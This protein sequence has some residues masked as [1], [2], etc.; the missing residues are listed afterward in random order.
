MSEKTSLAWWARPI[1]IGSLVSACLLPFGALGSR[2]GVWTFSIGFLLGSIGTVVA[3]IGLVLAL[4]ALFVA[5]RSGRAAERLPVGMGLVICLLTLAVVGVQFNIA[6]SVPPIHNISTDVD[7]PPE[8]SR[9]VAVRGGDSNL[10]DYDR[11]RLAPLQRR[12]YPWVKPLET[13]R[14]P[15]AAFQHASDLVARLGWELVHADAEAGLIEATDTSLWFGFKDD[16]VIRIRPTDS[17]SRVD[18]HSVSRVGGSDL[19]ANARRIGEFI[20]EFEM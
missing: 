13:E 8:M 7:D 17:G 18:L 4:V 16:V 5:F 1:L 3:A 6:R 11:E 20:R 2:F 14:D 12:A 15:S 19:G 10:W 9:L